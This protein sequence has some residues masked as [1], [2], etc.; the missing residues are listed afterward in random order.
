MAY[1]FAVDENDLVTG[2][3]LDNNDEMFAWPHGKGGWIRSPFASVPEV[4]LAVTQAVY[5]AG[6]ASPAHILKPS[7][8]MQGALVVSRTVAEVA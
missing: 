8:K 7:L 1:R 4:P 2:M 5:D 3:A 6:I